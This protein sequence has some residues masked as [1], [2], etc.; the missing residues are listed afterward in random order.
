MSRS[1][2]WRLERAFF[3]GKN[4]HSRR[5]YN[6]LCKGCVHPCKQSFW[7]MVSCPHYLS[8]RSPKCRN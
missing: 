6:K 5:H 7:V 4:V 1:K 8:L 3:L 2:K